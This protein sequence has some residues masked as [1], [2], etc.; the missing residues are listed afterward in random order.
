MARQGD[1][2]LTFP[3]GQKFWPLD[4]WPE[5]V[6]LDDLAHALSL[7]CRFAGHVRCFYSVGEHSVRVSRDAQARCRAAGWDTADAAVAGLAGLL[8]DGS[9]AYVH[10]IIRPLKRHLAGY[11]AVELRLQRCINARFGLPELAHEA[12]WV[13]EADAA[14]LWSEKRDLT[15]QNDLQWDEAQGSVGEALPEII[16][17]WTPGMAERAFLGRF[18]ELIGPAAAP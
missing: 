15:V 11:A 16:V 1:W 8:H 10:D 17:P 13:R 5:E 9:E 6:H 14:L 3:T 12:R 7:C 4:P 2:M 18:A